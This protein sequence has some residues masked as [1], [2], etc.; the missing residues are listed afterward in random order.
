[1]SKQSIRY[2][3][4]LA[5]EC[6]C[7]DPMEFMGNKYTDWGNE[8]EPAARA[9][10]QKK[11]GIPVTEVGF[12]GRG[13][14]A[15]IGCSPD[16]LIADANGNWLG[17]LEIKC[18]QVDTHVDYLLE[19]VLPTDYKLQVHGSMAVT[20]LPYW[21]FMSYF[22]GLNPLIIKVER[23]SF[24][25]TVS[26]ALDQFVTDYAPERERVLAAILP[27]REESII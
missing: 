19:G 23:D 26:E 15:P 10:F 16:G 17:G 9:L 27:A 7:D 3:R 8:Q 11:K 2:M 20:G 25:E 14:G 22:P 5:R 1:I 4:R 13:D 21:Y 12:V 24:T 18:P 6:V